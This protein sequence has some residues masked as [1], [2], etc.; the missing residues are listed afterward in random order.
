MVDARFRSETCVAAI[1]TLSLGG[2]S[3]YVKT[4]DH[5]DMSI[6]DLRRSANI[7]EIPEHEARDQNYTSLGVIE[8][9]AC[10]T[11]VSATVA[12]RRLAVDQLRLKAATMGADAITRP[13]CEDSES[14]DWANNCYASTICK[15]AAVVEPDN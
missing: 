11:D 5:Y 4:M 14:I 10:V 15:S 9:L 8:G 12:D 13:I 1:F 2:C 6:E 3:S 7:Y